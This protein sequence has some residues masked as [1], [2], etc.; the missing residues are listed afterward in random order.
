MYPLA[1][2]RVLSV[3][4]LCRAIRSHLERALPNR[5]R[6]KGE[7][8]KCKPPSNAGHVYFDLKDEQAQI[9]CVCWYSTVQTLDLQ[10]PL[11]DGA[12]FEVTG[13]IGTYPQRSQYQLVVEDVVSVGR[14]E[15][16]RRFELLKEKLKAQ[17]LF[18][19][20]RKRPV[21]S[22]IGHVAIVTSRGGA[23]LHDFLITCQRRGA[24]VRITFVHAAVQGEAAAP[25]LARAIRFAGTLDVDAVVV[26]RGGGSIEDLWAFNTEAVALAIAACSRPVISAVGHETDFTIAD[27]VA[28]MRAATPTAAAEHVAR[29]RVALLAAIATA[30]RR[31]LKGAVR[32]AASA[33]ERLERTET[34]LRKAPAALLSAR[35]QR[36]DELASAVERCS[37]RRRLAEARRRLIQ[38][39]QRL[40]A[41]ARRSIASR[42]SNLA[43]ARGR[44]NTLGPH[45]TLERG[46]A[47]VYGPDERIVK[48]IEQV[49][50]ADPMRVLIYDGRLAATITAKESP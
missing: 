37:P 47:I 4:Q 34:D 45:H 33:R 18:D 23:A 11:D 39:R 25:E 46:Y 14:G 12:C 30:T 35:A 13:R 7:V 29:E 5:V 36:V 41:V 10:F 16:Y 19:E 38:T 48:S 42:C 17:G 1:A 6:V 44:L 28:D 9:A 43:N 24:H 26:A 40:G 49:R 8:W 32:I 27:F 3:G 15:L 20:G 50:V 21:P 2:E 31:L 22:F